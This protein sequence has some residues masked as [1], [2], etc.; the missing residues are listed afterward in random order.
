V[1]SFSGPSPGLATIF[2]RLRFEI[3]LFVASYDSQGY[4]GGIRSRLHTGILSSPKPE[5][6]SESELLYDWRFT[7]N[8]FVLAPS[9]LR[10]TARF[11]S[12]L[13]TCSHCPYI[14]SSLTRGWVCHLQFLLGFAS[15][16]ILGSESRGTRDHILRPSFETSLFVVSYDSQGYGGGIR[17]LLHTVIS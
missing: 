17:L 13:N 8:Q 15:A 6:E 11:F 4:G 7:A 14:T 10:L 12:Q 3:S 9:P 1:H 16:V 2:Y 5:S